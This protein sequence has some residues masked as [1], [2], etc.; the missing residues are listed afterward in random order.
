[1]GRCRLAPSRVALL[2]KVGSLGFGRDGMR[3]ARLVRHGV[4]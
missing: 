3:V 4:P 1:M 2:V